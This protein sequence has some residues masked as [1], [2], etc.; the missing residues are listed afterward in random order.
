MGEA[1]TE[2]RAQN[3]SKKN[4]SDMI[5]RRINYLVTTM[6]STIC[7][8]YAECPPPTAP[9]ALLVLIS[10]GIFM[11][12]ENIGKASFAEKR[13]SKGPIPTSRNEHIKS[14]QVRLR[15]GNGFYGGLFQN[16]ICFLLH[17]WFSSQLKRVYEKWNQILLHTVNTLFRFCTQVPNNYFTI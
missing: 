10:V 17:H 6:M 4:R 11:G 9:P 15:V 13:L 5:F 8:K 1:F 14:S 7:G 2:V 3:L 12:M 16:V